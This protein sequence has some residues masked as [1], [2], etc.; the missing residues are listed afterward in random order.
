VALKKLPVATDPGGPLYT[1]DFVKTFNSRYAAGEWEDAESQAPAAEPAKP[2]TPKAVPGQ[3]LRR[4]MST[5]DLEA[6]PELGTQ[7]DPSRRLRTRNDLSRPETG[8]GYGRAKLPWE[9][10]TETTFHPD[11]GQPMVDLATHLHPETALA[12]TNKDLANHYLT[13][14]RGQD[15]GIPECPGHQYAGQEPSELAKS[16]LALEDTGTGNLR[17]VPEL[18]P[19]GMLGETAAELY[20]LRLTQKP[21]HV[22]PGA[23]PEVHTVQR[24]LMNPYGR[25]RDGLGKSLEILGRSHKTERDGTRTPLS[26]P[27]GAPMVEDVARQMGMLASIRG[28]G[29][30][31]MMSRL[32]HIN[33]LNRIVA[34][35]GEGI[36]RRA[37][38][39]QGNPGSGGSR[40]F[41][42]L[43]DGEKPFRIS[44]NF[45][46]QTR[47]MGEHLLPVF[48]SVDSVRNRSAL[49]GVPVHNDLFGNIHRM[50]ACPYDTFVGGIHAA[51]SMLRLNE[52]QECYQGRRL[53]QDASKTD[54]LLRVLFPL[55]H[56]VDPN[57]GPRYPIDPHGPFTHGVKKPLR[58]ATARKRS[59]GKILTNHVATTLRNIGTPV[60]R[61][62]EAYTGETPILN[63]SVQF[64]DVPDS[65][66]ARRLM[67]L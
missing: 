53:G 26:R 64:Q 19:K 39:S 45:R 15:C 23:K 32:G 60:S 29:A 50:C 4:N 20:P 8:T 35:R 28:R 14:V 22:A 11:T 3:P 12:E 56:Y 24:L 42:G 30:M 25:I 55:H 46:T 1:G 33:P 51:R 38:G 59:A 27:N 65:D 10:I 58:G 13:H 34:Q 43:A 62:Q 36:A 52:L 17:H 44:D 54:H 7:R 21:E 9:D 67:G 47:T 61:G 31:T 63:P 16:H 57:L 18:Q 6:N 48:G 5:E 49:E 37:D 41:V 2:E 66:E 40:N